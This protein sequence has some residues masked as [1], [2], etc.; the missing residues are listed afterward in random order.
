MN[1]RDFEMI[2]AILGAYRGMGADELIED[3]AEG[4]A[5]KLSERNDRFDRDRFMEA[6]R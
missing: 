1:R 5:L 4:F 6:T 2:A 3:M